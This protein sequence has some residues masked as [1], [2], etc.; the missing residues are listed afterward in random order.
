[1]WQIVVGVWAIAGIKFKLEEEAII[2]ILVA[3]TYLESGAGGSKNVLGL[4][5]CHNKPWPAK[6][7]T[8]LCCHL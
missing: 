1:M 5:S 6:S 8:Q 3:V 4:E 7:C 2:E